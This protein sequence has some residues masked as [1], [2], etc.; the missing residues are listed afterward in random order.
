[1]ME[2]GWTPEPFEADDGTVP[3]ERFVD[4][5]S[6]SKFV[7]LD[8]AIRLVLAVR[9]IDLV[10]TEWL[11]ALGRGLHE[12]RVRHDADEIA[13]MFGGDTPGVK[14]PVERILLRVFV[15]FHG[16]RVVLLI[17]GYDKGRDPKERRQ[18]REIAQARR[19]LVQFKERQRR[20]R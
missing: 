20:S 12:F 11:K 7:T 1:M 14:V 18:Q 4:G 2:S 6:D 13:G 8:T 5:L 15:H 17:G 16:D 3:F 9:G 19:L 10:R